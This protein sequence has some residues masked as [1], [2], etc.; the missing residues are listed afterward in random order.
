MRFRK[1]AWFGVQR[2]SYASVPACPLSRRLLCSALPAHHILWDTTKFERNHEG[3]FPL[4]SRHVFL[5]ACVIF[6][7]DDLAAFLSLIILDLVIQPLCLEFKL[8]G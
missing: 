7:V 3:Y 1:G 6:H 8:S 5:L 2:A 4:G